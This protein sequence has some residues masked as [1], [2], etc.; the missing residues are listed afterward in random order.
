MSLL[1]TNL[2]ILNN[3]QKAKH[4][5]TDYWGRKIYILGDGNKA[6][7]LDDEEFYSITSNY[8]EPCCPLKKEYQPKDIEIYRFENQVI[9]LEDWENY[10]KPIEENESDKIFPF[11]KD[12]WEYA[13]DKFSNKPYQ[14]IWSIVNG[15]SGHLILLNGFHKVNV[16]D[17]LVCEIPW[18]LGEDSDSGVYL[19]VN[20]EDI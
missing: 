10:F 15:E 11:Y 2:I 17:Y 16:L 1:E 12:A 7:L 19:E 8:G 5:Y 4:S 18:G 9:S 14:H 20:Y 13:E 3:G 6:V